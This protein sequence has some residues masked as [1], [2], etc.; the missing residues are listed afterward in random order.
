MKWE[1]LDYNPGQPNGQKALWKAFSFPDFKTAL[2]FANKVG[3]I[4]EELN[5]HPDINLSWGRV[6]IW[7]TSHDAHK[8]TEKDHELAKKI[9]QIKD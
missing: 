5:H 2:A 7:T 8:I 1:E 6:S 4:A 3:A 9:D